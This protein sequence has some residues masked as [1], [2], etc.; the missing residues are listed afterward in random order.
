M[1]MPVPIPA[2]LA[3][4]PI[5]PDDPAATGIMV[6]VGRRVVEPAVEVPVVEAVVGEAMAAIA[7][8]RVTIAAAAIDVGGAIAAA[9][10][11]H[12]AA[13]DAGAMK[14]AAAAKAAAT[15]ETASAMAAVTAANFDRHS[16]GRVF[17]DRQ[18][19]RTCQRKR[20]SSLLW[21]GR[22]HQHSGSRQPRAPDKSA[23]G[24]CNLRHF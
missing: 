15:A 24:T 5:G 6:V 19:T 8:A 1:A 16:L 20:F 2:D 21:R 7:Q 22:Q 14:S 18:R 9:A 13:A 12:T 3:R 11:C 4:A 10:N 17:R 23:R